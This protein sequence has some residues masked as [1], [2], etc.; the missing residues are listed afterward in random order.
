MEKHLNE[1]YL[2]KNTIKVFKFLEELRKSGAINMA[3]STSYVVNHFNVSPK[4]ARKLILKWIK[5][6]KDENK[7]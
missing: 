4:E 1:I 3:G 5:S 2:N 7:I 6:K